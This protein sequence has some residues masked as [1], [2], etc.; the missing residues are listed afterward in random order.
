MSTAVTDILCSQCKTEQTNMFTA[1][2][3]LLD[4]H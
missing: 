2:T 1:L 4:L 3:Y